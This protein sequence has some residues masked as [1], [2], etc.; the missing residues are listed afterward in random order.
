MV[1]GV[2]DLWVSGGCA[3]ME[4][5]P[6][7][8]PGHMVLCGQC[9]EGGKRTSQRIC[10]IWTSVATSL[11]RLVSFHLEAKFKL[12]SMWVHKWTGCEW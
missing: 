8:S 3:Q 6:L 10:S 4:E 1:L 7:P 2:Y 5:L 12:L 11:R 9:V